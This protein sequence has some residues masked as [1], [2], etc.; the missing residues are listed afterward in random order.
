MRRLWKWL[1]RRLKLRRMTSAELRC[2]LWKHDVDR[3]SGS[4]SRRG[5]ELKAA[6]GRLEAVGRSLAEDLDEAKLLLEKRADVV[7]ALNSELEILRDSTVPGLVAASEAM[8]D[9][10]R[11]LTAI[12]QGRQI[13]VSPER[14]DLE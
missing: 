4:L 12:E 5:R 10:W 1:C 8:L 2:L 11:T 6:R 9:K 14:G 7:D 13:G 3:L